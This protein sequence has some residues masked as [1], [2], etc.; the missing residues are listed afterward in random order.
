MS[1][2]V[3]YQHK[4]EKQNQ[5]HDTV[6]KAV[7]RI[8]GFEYSYFLYGGAIRGGK[9][10]VCLY[11]F[12][13]LARLFPGSR[14]HVI[15][16]DNPALESTSIPSMEKLIGK[17]GA[18]FTWK[19]SKGSVQVV[20]TNGSRIFFMAE[21]IQKD[22]ELKEFL[23]LETNGILLEQMEALSEK[24]WERAIERI[25]SWYIDPMPIPLLLGTFNPSPG[26]VKKKI[27]DKFIKGLL[28]KPY[29]YQPALPDDNPFVTK[30]QWANWSNLDPESQKIM[31]KGIWS[32]KIG[33][34]IWAYSFDEDRHV[35]P[36]RIKNANGV[37]VPNPFFELDKRLP[38]HLIFDFNVDPMTCLV[39][40][41][42]GTEW[43]KIIKEY[44]L[45]SS[46]IFELL[47]RIKI[48]LAGYYLVA[49]GDAT[50]RARQ[51]NNKGAKS[52]LD[53]I[54]RE[55]QLSDRQMQFPPVNPSVKNTRVVVNSV[56]HKHPRFFISSDCLFLIDDLHT[57]KTDD[58][59]ELDKNKIDPTK[60]H[61][62]DNL[63]YFM[64]NYFRTWLKISFN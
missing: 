8:T 23:G 33:G 58:F 27:Y 39:A 38:V 14:W 48:D 51:G 4:N 50:G 29:F 37:E 15:R 31:I 57:V 47:D 6:M 44:R 49:T 45:L 46:D 19:R 21:S 9:T 53:S 30:E 43:G 40:Q 5:F 41:R 35:L 60:T 16:E 64:W 61:L 59:G 28:S 11:I 18:D 20:F 25:G 54:R 52:Y 22:K 7:A 42:E 63:R 3:V 36:A 1:D 55:L 32:F 26:W 24:L 62:L 12:V 13:V 17:E 34:N 10:F 56:F 2:I